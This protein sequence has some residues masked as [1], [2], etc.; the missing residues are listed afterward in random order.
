MALLKDIKNLM[1]GEKSPEELYQTKWDEVL[2]IGDSFAKQ[3]TSETD[4][5]KVVAHYVTG[6]PHT[7][8]ESV[9]GKG[10][11]GASWW[12]TRKLLIEELK[13][14][15]PKVLILTH[16]EMQRIPSDEDY[17]LNSASVFNLEAYSTIRD[18]KLLE[19]M[20][21]KEVLLAGQQYYTHLFSKDFHI[22]AQKQWFYEIDHLVKIY[23]IPFVIHIHTFAPWDCVDVHKFK[24]GITFD[25]PIWPLSDDYAM[26]HTAKWKKVNNLEVPDADLW[27]INNNRNHFTEKNNVKLGELIIDALNNYSNGIKPLQL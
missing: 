11:S 18:Q 16:T 27:F 10:F 7:F 14:N 24:Y 23:N 9:R 21:P 19:D 5:P 17:G 8:K 4:W 12:S 25:Q 13:K 26:M 2:I 1:K 6:V 22:W 3:R 15:V 20:V